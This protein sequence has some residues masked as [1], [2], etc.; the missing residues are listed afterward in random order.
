MRSKITDIM[1]VRN[2]DGI[3]FFITNRKGVIEVWCKRRL[4]EELNKK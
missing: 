1:E 4:I 3:Y 2:K